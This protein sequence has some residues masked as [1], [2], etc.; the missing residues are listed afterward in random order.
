MTLLRNLVV[1]LSLYSK[2]PMPQ[3]EWRKDDMKYNLAFLPVVGL[4]IGAIEYLLVA[5]FSRYD[6]PEVF[7][8]AVLCAVP[9]LITGGFH[10]DGFMDT[11]DAF[12]SFKSKEEKLKILEDP[13]IGAFAVIS[14]LIYACLFAWSLS[15]ICDG[16]NL[17][18]LKSVMDNDIESVNVFWNSFKKLPIFIGLIFVLGRIVTG[19]TSLVLPKARKEGMLQNETSS[20]GRGCLVALI[21]ELVLCLG[22]MVYLDLALAVAESTALLLTTLY[23]RK[24]TGAELGGV[25]GDTAGYFLVLSELIMLM[26]EAAYV[27]MRYR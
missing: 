10:M 13:H 22:F 3:F 14:V 26:T 27:F 7:R 17:Q 19:I 5:L 25:T 6:F 9:L 20:A 18:M 2:I 15:I 11:Q 4:V 21:I 16:Y 1:A 23:Y 8:I 12:K 24:K